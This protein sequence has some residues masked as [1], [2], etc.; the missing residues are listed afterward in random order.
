MMR[1]NAFEVACSDSSDFFFFNLSLINITVVKIR[2]RLEENEI[3]GGAYS[4]RRY[5]CGCF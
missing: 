5:R 1:L 4:F 2:R 3:L